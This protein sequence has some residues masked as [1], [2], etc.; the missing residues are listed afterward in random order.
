MQKKN[1]NAAL[2]IATQTGQLGPQ[3]IKASRVTL[4][5]LLPRSR[6]FLS[7]FTSAWVVLSRLFV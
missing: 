2:V 7:R 6:F 4:G 3:F 5:V 1:A